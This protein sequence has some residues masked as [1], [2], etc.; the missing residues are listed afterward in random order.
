MRLS[1]IV[2]IYNVAPYLQQCLDSICVS[3][4]DE[5]VEVVLVND[6]ST[7]ASLAIAQAWTEATNVKASPLQVQLV[8]Q[9]NAGL[10]AARNA[11]LKAATGDY[12]LFLDS[13]DWLAEHAIDTLL[14]A[15]SDDDVDILGFAGQSFD[16]ERQELLPADVIPAASYESGYAYYCR[17]AT[18]PRQFPFECVVLRAYKRTFLLQNDLWFGVGLYHEDN[19]FTPQA[20]YRAGKVREMDT[21]LYIYRRRSGTI[22]TSVGEKHA[23]DVIDIANRLAKET[24]ALPFPD[25]RI[26]FQKITQLYQRPFT[27]ATFRQG[28]RWRNDVDF[29]LYKAVS[30]T[31][32]RHRANYLLIR[33]VPWLFRMLYGTKS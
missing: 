15:V 6:G 3:A 1:V 31:K 30:R 20:C 25:K 26:P 5:N 12:V 18:A 11:G 22:S 17:F 21:V 14:R 23:R 32:L 33:F 16:E 8:S 27:F 2:P 24:L 19:L 29:R 7:D 28:Y 13:D 9:A 10:S 4:C